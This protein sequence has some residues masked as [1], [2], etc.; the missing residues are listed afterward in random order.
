MGTIYD[1]AKSLSATTPQGSIYERA[2][3]ISEKEISKEPTIPEIPTVVKAYPSTMELLAD[4][5][6]DPLSLKA[7]PTKFLSVAGQNIK[8]TFINE[9]EAAAQF[10]ASFTSKERPISEKI[11]A[12]LKLFGASAGVVFAPITTLFQTAKTIPVLGSVS[13]LFEAPIVALGET[14]SNIANI[15]VDE[16]P[17]NE[18][19]KENIREGMKEIGAL[20]FQLGGLKVGAKTQEI[21]KT[22]TPE[23]IKR[24]GKQDAQTIIDKAQEIV[25]IADKPVAETL[26][27]EPTEARK[28][29]EFLP[30]GK[31]VKDLQPLAQEARKLSFIKREKQIHPLGETFDIISEGKN[32]GHYIGKKTRN[33]FELFSLTVKDEFQK[34]G[35]G[36]N[37][38]SKIFQDNPKLS[39]IIIDPTEA[40]KPFWKK[41]GAEPIGLTRRW[42]LTK[43]QLTDI[44]NKAVKGVEK[45]VPKKRKFVEVPREQLPVKPTE[46]M[47]FETEK[48]VSGLE[49]RMK[50]IF[51]TNIIKAKAEAEARGLDISVYDKMNKAEQ[52]RMSAKYVERTPQYEVL[53]VLEGKR[54]APKGLLNNAI[55]LALEEKSLR[56][57]NVN[58]AIKLASLRSTRMGQE[59]SI[60]TEVGGLSPVSGMNEIIRARRGVA[61]KKLKFG[62]KLETKKASAVKEIKTEQTK[63]QLKMSEVS[64]LLSDIVC[65]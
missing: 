44:W 48:R 8:D 37:A 2:K 30:T 60:L 18:Q 23:L 54:E 19:H 17:I 10:V 27:K 40:S 1:K 24:F 35:I 12:G 41:V 25:D 46:R 43:S 49:A 58:L 36:T 13:K 52:L 15:L 9:A 63:L 56:D 5:Q 47:G 32:V 11:G 29:E 4:L 28:A 31:I 42:E 21:I 26:K 39:R 64:K 62:E 34:R 22:K 33:D 38:L 6:I 14:G 53:E 65:K 50:G 57:K 3:I 59:I 16:L 45:A 7:D 55:M 61:E 20:A 51:E